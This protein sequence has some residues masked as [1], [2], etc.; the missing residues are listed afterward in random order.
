MTKTEGRKSRWTVP[1]NK[2]EKSLFEPA[3][4][5]QIILLFQIRNAPFSLSSLLPETTV[6]KKTRKPEKF[7]LNYN[8][9]LVFSK[10]NYFFHHST[11][12]WRRI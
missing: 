3:T 2:F 1:L 11:N 10:M 7:I 6:I 5:I 4:A 9:V 12:C 8:F